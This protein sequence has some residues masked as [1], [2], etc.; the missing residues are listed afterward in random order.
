M[1]SFVIKKD[2]TKEPFDEQKIK[3]SIAAAA[4][5]ANLPEERKNELVD[6][7]SALAIQAAAG[8]EE[9]ATSEIRESILSE[10]DRIEPSVS[11]AWRSHS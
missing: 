11:A 2:G 6:Q 4:T 7:V 8:K 10:L 3:N 1:A 5:G 9:M